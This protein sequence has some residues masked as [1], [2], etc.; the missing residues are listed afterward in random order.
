MS[1]L[2]ISMINLA[3]HIFLMNRTNITNLCIYIGINSI[4]KIGYVDVDIVDMLFIQ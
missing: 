3:Q 1:S 2:T 4:D